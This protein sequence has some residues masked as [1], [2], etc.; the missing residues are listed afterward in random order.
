MATN[1]LSIGVNISITLSLVKTIYVL[2]VAYYCAY[3]ANQV[4]NPLNIP[5]AK[6]TK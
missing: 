5:K 2:I 4:K 3:K 1:R 6:E